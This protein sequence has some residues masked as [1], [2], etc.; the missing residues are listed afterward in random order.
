MA[1]LD[2]AAPVPDLIDDSTSD[3][4]FPSFDGLTWEYGT[5]MHNLPPNKM[6]PSI[7][8]IKDGFFH[9]FASPIDA[10]FALM[11]YSF[12]ELMVYRMNRYALQYMESQ[13]NI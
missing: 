1:F 11:P 2:P 12:W 4:Q 3:E 9:C 7:T 13:K 8:T 10:M 5:K 6:K